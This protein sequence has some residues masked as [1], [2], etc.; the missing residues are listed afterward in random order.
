MEPVA[1]MELSR[2]FIYLFMNQLMGTDLLDHILPQTSQFMQIPFLC[3]GYEIYV[4]QF[5]WDYT[6]IQQQML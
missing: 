4:L 2:L 5:I 6:L 3:V 1:E